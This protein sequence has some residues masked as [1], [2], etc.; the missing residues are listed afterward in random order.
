MNGM[1]KIWIRMLEYI[2]PD[3]QQTRLSLKVEKNVAEFCNLAEFFLYLFS[4]SITKFGILC[5]YVPSASGLKSC[6][7]THKDLSWLSDCYDDAIY[8][9]AGLGLIQSGNNYCYYAVFPVPD[10]WRFDTDPDPRIPTIGLRIRNP[11][12]CSFLQWSS[13]CQPKIIVFL[14]NYRTVV[15]FLYIIPIYIYII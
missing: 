1:F 11:G 7:G 12:T 9:R 2:I 13:R 10:L 3:L 4:C 5:S 8:F 15:S 6:S 14:I